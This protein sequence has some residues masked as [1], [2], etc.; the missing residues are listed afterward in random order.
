MSQV[1]KWGY[2]RNVMVH[3]WQGEGNRLG[4]PVDMQASWNDS[5]VHAQRFFP[6]KVQKQ[7]T[8]TLF[9]DVSDVLLTYIRVGIKKACTRPRGLVQFFSFSQFLVFWLI[10]WLV[11]LGGHRHSNL[12]TLVPLREW[13]YNQTGKCTLFVQLY[14][15]KVILGTL[16]WCALV[17]SKLVG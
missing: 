17:V 12:A 3:A 4:I 13:N 16:S 7:M 14:V 2:K 8:V 1:L 5:S 6:P 9:D 10:P 15:L 11:H